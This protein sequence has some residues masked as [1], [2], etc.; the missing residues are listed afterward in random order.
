MLVGKKL[1]FLPYYKN[2]IVCKKPFAEIVK[3]LNEATVLSN[4]SAVDS[5][6]KAGKKFTGYFGNYH[7]SL[8]P[9]KRDTGEYMEHRSKRSNYSRETGMSP[10]LSGAFTVEPEKDVLL[11]VKLT[12]SPVYFVIM[13][14]IWLAIIL[15]LLSLNVFVLLIAIGWAIIVKCSCYSSAKSALENLF[16]IVGAHDENE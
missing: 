2:R 9:V 14:I 13:S 11:D 5:N 6:E 16:E 4:N 3:D 8:H 7:F 10:E 1:F 12:Y 15:G